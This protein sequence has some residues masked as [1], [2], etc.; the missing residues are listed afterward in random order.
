[1]TDFHYSVHIADQLPDDLEKRLRDGECWPF[2][3]TVMLDLPIGKGK[4]ALSCRTWLPGLA[5]FQFF[6]KQFV[7]YSARPSSAGGPAAAG[8][9]SPR[10]AL[11]DLAR[12][13]A[14][15]AMD[16]AEEAACGSDARKKLQNY[17][18]SVPHLV[19]QWQELRRK[20]G[21]DDDPTCEVT[22]ENAQERTK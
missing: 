11:I 17:V 18:D 6:N 8:C 3:F 5:H 4:R 2:K 13:V 14:G 15:A 12:T 16:I 19:E 20:H 9:G 21:K 1:M 22:M 7:C 10:Y